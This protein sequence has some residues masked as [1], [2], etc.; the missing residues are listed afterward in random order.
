MANGSCGQ[1]GEEVAYEIAARAATPAQ[2]ASGARHQPSGSTA[3]S[4][5]S[6][7][8]ST[9]SRTQILP[10]SPSGSCCSSVPAANVQCPASS[11]Q[12]W[13][14]LAAGGATSRG[15]CIADQLPLHTPAS[16][17]PHGRHPR[18]AAMVTPTAPCMVLV[19]IAAAGSCSGHATADEFVRS[20]GPG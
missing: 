6:R 4:T 19:S 10:S 1:T 12:R 20:F 8:S 17:R 11:A 2:S 16:H 13:R 9:Q 3:R 15:E 7:A 18:C 5:S 14:R